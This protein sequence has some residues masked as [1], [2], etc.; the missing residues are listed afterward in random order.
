MKNDKQIEEWISVAA[1]IWKIYQ[2]LIEDRYQNQKEKY[3]NDLEML[4]MCI[5][6]EN[7]IY[8]Y[9]CVTIDN[10]NQYCQTIELLISRKKYNVKTKK[11]ISGR[12]VKYLINLEYL[13]PFLSMQMD[14]YTN[15]LENQ[16]AIEI[17]YDVEYLKHFFSRIDYYFQKATTKSE[18][19]NLIRCYYG[20]LFEFKLSEHLLDNPKLLKD[21]TMSERE[22]CLLFHHN[23]LDVE[24]YYEMQSSN[25]INES[26]SK[27]F[28]ENFSTK[29]LTAL[30]EKINLEAILSILTKKERSRF[31]YQTY[32]NILNNPY[33]KDND[34]LKENLDF[35]IKII[36]EFYQNT[37]NHS[38]ETKKKTLS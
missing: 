9:L 18:K 15:Q 22:K 25:W 37:V 31:M 24:Y 28:D 32:T 2:E 3:Q 23:P 38:Q 5:D 33:Y 11:A 27:I 4:K 6:L 35:F 29:N 20:I 26:L 36:G 34:A 17:Q 14:S 16:I 13:N 30:R 8:Q 21:F 19:K 12:M 7:Q 1:T 10:F